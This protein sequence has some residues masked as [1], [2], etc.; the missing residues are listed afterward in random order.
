M[1]VSKSISAVFMFLLCACS[2]SGGQPAEGGV[3]AAPG[4]AVGLSPDLRRFIRA[5]CEREV[6]CDETGITFEDIESC[7]RGYG[8]FF[9]GAEAATRVLPSLDSCLTG[10][11]GLSCDMVNND[12]PAPG[13]E[14]TVAALSSG[15]D[16]A[17]F[18]Q[19][20][21]PFTRP[22]RDGV[23]V[24]NEEG[25]CGTCMPPKAEGA[26][27][28][29]S[30]ECGD[31]LTCEAGACV[32]ELAKEAACKDQGQ[33]A[34]DECFEGKC[35]NNQ[36]ILGMPC[37]ENDWCGGTL[38]CV[39]RK[40]VVRSGQGEDCSDVFDCRFGLSCVDGKCA[41]ISECGQGREGD[42]CLGGTCGGALVC[43]PREQRCVT[44]V[45]TGAECARSG[46][47]TCARSDYCA[48]LNG[49]SEPN[50]AGAITLPTAFACKRKVP[51]G[52]ECSLFGDECAT[53]LCNS[54]GK[55][56]PETVCR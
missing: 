18:G 30:E 48:P 12:G 9:C 1:R 44:P 46:M 53:G 15:V 21:Q 20:C 13:C 2:S 37:D 31:S 26:T 51:D 16:F 11:K 4:A 45:P 19:S 47:P 5:V 25:M 52:S 23:C 8:G 29:D 41:A 38:R 42:A 32:P 36:D 43:D 27:C 14:L 50:D 3:P 49:S 39:D 22:C 7:E 54:E 6:A 10:L 35:Q 56:G 34:T 55:C 17:R 40:C 24:R 28:E 33:C